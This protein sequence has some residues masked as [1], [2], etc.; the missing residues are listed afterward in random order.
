MRF[1]SKAS[2]VIGVI[3]VIALT[4]CAADARPRQ[5]NHNRHNPYAYDYNYAYPGD[6]Q[7]RGSSGYRNN[8]QQRSQRSYDVYD[9]RG[10]YIGSDPDPTV[11]SQLSHDP[12]QGRD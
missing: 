1:A 8:I 11:R 6:V 5:N 10:H 3:G 2:Y 7:S 9:I 12:S 4:A